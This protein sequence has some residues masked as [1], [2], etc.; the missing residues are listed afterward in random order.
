MIKILEADYLYIFS[1]GNPYFCHTYTYFPLPY[2]GLEDPTAGFTNTH[3]SALDTL[4]AWQKYIFTFRWGKHT[5]KKQ[6]SLIYKV[7]TNIFW[8]SNLVT[9]SVVWRQ[10]LG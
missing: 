2:K 3:I 8:K 4:L 10:H 7:I 1:F 5:F 9:P 6:N